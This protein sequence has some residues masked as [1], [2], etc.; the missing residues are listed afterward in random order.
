ME[1]ET[2]PV[3]PVTQHY[4]SYEMHRYVLD[5]RINA[6]IEVQ[7]TKGLDLFKVKGINPDINEEFHGNNDS[8]Q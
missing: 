2:S 4:K 3:L 8:L 5:K 6:E 7:N 1:T